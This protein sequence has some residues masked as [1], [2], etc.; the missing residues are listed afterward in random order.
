LRLSLPT[1]A[2]VLGVLTA[3][4][5]FPTLASAQSKPA[6]AQATDPEFAKLVKEW[7]T[8][9]E[10]LSPLVDF[11]PLKKG[12]PTPKEALGRY[13]GTPNRLTSTTEAYAYYRALEKAS[14]RVKI[15]L[16]GKTDEGR[17][18]MI[19]NISNEQTIKDLELYRGYLGQI[20]DPRKYTEAQ[21]KDVIAKAKPIYYVSG[22][23]HSPETGPP[24]M[25][26]ELAYRLVA[27]DSPMYQGIRDNVIVAINPV[28]EPDGRDRIVDWY[29]RHK[30][31][32]TDERTTSPGVPYWGKYVFH[33]NNRDINY[34]QVTMK[35]VLDWYLQWHPPIMH[36]LHESVPFLYTFSGQAPQNPTLDPILYSELPWFSNYEKSQMAK[37]GMP[38]VWDFGFVDMWSPGYLA[39]M[40]SNHN[41]IIR[42]YETF[43][44]GGATTMK[45]TVAPPDGGAGQT[46]REWYR[47]WP[48]YKEVV[49]SMRN[50]TNYME[51][52][53]LSA[54]ELTSKFPKVIL[55]NFYKKSFNSIESGKKD[56]PYGY[57]IPGGQKDQTRVAMLINL[58]RIQG[59]EV[60]KATAEVSVKE[61]KFPAGSYVIKRDQPYGRLAKIL[62][63]KQT[64]PDANLRTYDDT[65]WTMGLMNQT[66]V[67][68]I[69]DLAILQA[70]VE[71]VTTVKLQ[72]SQSGTG[73]FVAV[74]N[75]GANNM[76]TLRYKLK[77][78]RTLTNEKAVTTGGT[79]IPAGSL[80]FDTQGNDAAAIKSAVES[81][82]LT[83][84]SMASPPEVPTHEV[85]LPR[86]A[87]FSTW[88][89]TQEVG[90]VRHAF[91]YYGIPFTLIYKEQVRAGN[92]SK[93]FDVLL[94]PNQGRTAKGL[95][96]DLPNR[97][98]KPLPYKKDPKFPTLGGYG[99]S[100]DITGGMGLEGAAEIDKFVNAGGSLVTLAAASYFPPEFGLARQIDARAPSPTFYAPGP[101][102]EAEILAPEHPIFYGY[103]AKTIPVR[104]GNGP[105]L[106]VPEI[107]K[108]RILMKYPGQD[109]SV[110]SGLFRGAGEIRDRPAIVDL[111]QGKGQIVLFAGNPCYRWQNHGE[112][113]M[114]FNTILHWNDLLASKAP[115][116]AEKPA[117]ATP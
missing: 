49:W 37:F 20:A 85:D 84:V 94:I 117:V 116:P 63:E 55:E 88:G 86:L 12:I 24:E 53:V 78:V 77:G 81:L 50:N 109:R 2:L 18:Q 62:L 108:E 102:I 74:L 14:P 93:D 87:I 89:N 64:F 31:D 92:L 21:M 60:G 30:I 16:M 99:E 7:T 95:V 97:S 32:E 36:D 107:M 13:V 96:F 42:M 66:E 101:I 115:L 54:L 11:L 3:F 67:K 33:D 91:D 80:W 45:R 76:I 23:Q 112:F 73:R 43:G 17:D 35:N 68:E 58:L 52:G 82:G 34:S 40:S 48:P 59:I 4:T 8:K 44:N 19:V 113:G 71:P 98:G 57:V 56:A 104:Y 27:D 110:M 100:D 28:V 15:V 26:M 38:G 41:G 47:P 61:G 103:T 114:L 69:A 70:A 22:G 90:W 10:F 79:Q 25:L 105:L 39:F 65:G 83:A 5:G 9:P 111:P 72:G 1:R 29:H 6:P 106:T 46:S 75:H 51:T